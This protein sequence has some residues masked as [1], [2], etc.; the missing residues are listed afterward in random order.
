M[1][2]RRQILQPPTVRRQQRI[3]IQQ[4]R[5]MMQRHLLQQ[6]KQQRRRPQRVVVVKLKSPKGVDVEERSE[7]DYSSTA[8]ALCIP[9]S[10]GSASFL[11]VTNLDRLME[12]LTPYIPA[13]NLLERPHEESDAELHRLPSIS[14]SIDP[15][16]DRRAKTVSDLNIQRLNMLSRGKKFVKGSS[17][18]EADIANSPGRTLFQFLEHE[19]PHNRRPLTDKVDLREVHIGYHQSILLS[20][21]MTV[22]ED[23]ALT[24]T[25]ISSCI[26]ISPTEEVQEL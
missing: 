16:A 24:G 26:P 14:G 3:L 21:I 7:A 17:G 2:R 1:R 18:S 20:C 19:Q 4:Q 13:Q 23:F 9:F 5:Q 11:N 8:P 10:V 6:Q 12:S 22:V 15:E 25:D